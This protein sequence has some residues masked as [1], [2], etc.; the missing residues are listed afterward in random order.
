MAGIA[1]EHI[2]KYIQ[3]Y[4]HRCGGIDVHSEIDISD[5]LLVECLV[6]HDYACAV[7]EEIHLSY[8]GL[9]C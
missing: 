2:R 1:L 7:D 5:R 3:C 4:K 6:A 9:D 8:L